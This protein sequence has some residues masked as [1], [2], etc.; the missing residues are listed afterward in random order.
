MAAAIGPLRSFGITTCDSQLLMMQTSLTPET[1]FELIRSCPVACNCPGLATPGPPNTIDPV[2][3][4]SPIDAVGFP[5]PIECC[6]E[7]CCPTKP[8]TMAPTVAPTMAPTMAPTDSPTTVAPTG[9][10]TAAP[11]GGCPLASAYDT[12][13]SDDDPDNDVPPGD[14]DML[15]NECGVD[16]MGNDVCCAVCIMDVCLTTCA[17]AYPGG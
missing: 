9:S 7:P 4:P 16:D 10:P 12:V 3:C 6:V 11:T 8:P 2:P 5:C 1:M 14:P 13:N 15:C 17:S